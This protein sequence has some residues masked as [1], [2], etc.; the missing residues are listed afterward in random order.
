MMISSVGCRWSPFP[1]NAFARE[2]VVELPGAVH[3]DAADASATIY[4]MGGV[5]GKVGNAAR[6]VNGNIDGQELLN[7]IR[8]EYNFSDLNYIR[9]TGE[10]LLEEPSRLIRD[11]ALAIVNNS[12]LLEITVET[13]V[14]NDKSWEI[15][16]DFMSGATP[17][18]DN[19]C[20]YIKIPPDAERVAFDETM[21]RVIRALG[22]CIVACRSQDLRTVNVIIK[23]DEK[24]SIN[25]IDKFVSK[26]VNI[27]SQDDMFIDIGALALHTFNIS[28][29]PE[30][31]NEEINS[32]ASLCVELLKDKEFQSSQI[33]VLFPR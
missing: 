25:L 33:A 12:E 16:E 30:R 6:R 14:P 29:L 3:H 19:V 5:A 22:G 28:M 31:D 18:I 32:T 26:I 21:K 24:S 13:S 23:I 9:F 7:L 10:C 1:P 27:C 11:F 4:A 17:L 15:L 20:L 8:D 2:A